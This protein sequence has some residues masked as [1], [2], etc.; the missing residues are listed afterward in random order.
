[1]FKF[2]TDKTDYKYILKKTQ[3]GS[4]TSNSS[5]INFVY[6]KGARSTAPGPSVVF[7]HKVTLHYK[8]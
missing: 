6:K 7:N 2:S 8:K 1:M 3:T 5:I 4:V